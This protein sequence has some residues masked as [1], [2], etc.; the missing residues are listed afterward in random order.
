MGSTI[1]RCLTSQVLRQTQR[2]QQRR[3]GRSYSNASAS[4]VD[5]W[6]QSM[7]TR[8]KKVSHDT[9]DVERASQLK[10]I[11]PTRQKGDYVQDAHIGEI[12]PPSHHLVFFRPKPMLRDL[13][14]DGS[15]TEYNAPNPYTRRM[16][17]GGKMM[18]SNKTSLRIGDEMTQ[19]VTVPKVELK[20]DMIFVHQQLSIYPGI[21]S[22]ANE[23]WAVKEIR[24]HVFRKQEDPLKT[25]APIQEKNTNAITYDDEINAS[26]TD[27][28]P[29]S[30]QYTPNTPSLF[31]YSAL[32]HNPHK[33]HY[34][35]PWTINKERH[36]APLV[37][38][39]LNATLLVELASGFDDRLLKSFSYR[40]TGPMIVDKEIKM[41]GKWNDRG[42]L[43]LDAAQGGKIGMKATAEYH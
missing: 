20:K 27:Q 7:V 6:I 32:T 3:Y 1:Q 38:G 42:L 18:W 13:G 15:S 34:D 25:S 21:I 12:L 33:V 2:Q 37:H 9:I 26:D 36:P 29:V 22:D 10:R 41:T 28:A 23:A 5:H 19:I 40:A 11:L 4:A 16:W 14:S 8:P 30:F 43:E 24:T 39:P 17:A 35:H 31:L